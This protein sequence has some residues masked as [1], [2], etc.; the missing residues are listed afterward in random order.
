MDN[1]VVSENKKSF[2][3]NDK[4]LV[5]GMLSFY[6]LCIVGLIAGTFLWLGQMNRKIS[7]NATSTAQVVATQDANATATAIVRTTEQAKFG[8]VEKFDSNNQNWL[9]EKDEDE[10]AKSNI[11]V[12]DGMYIWDIEEVKKTFIYWADFPFNNNMKDFHVYVDTKLIANTPGDVCSGFLFRVAEEDWDKGGY[13]FS[14]CN[15]STATISYHTQ[16]DGWENITRLFDLGYANEW[17]RLEIIGKGT[18]FQFLINGTQAYEMDDDRQE[19]GGLA[20]VIEVNEKV[21]V[22]VLFDNFG[23]QR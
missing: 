14:L 17:N 15:D 5:C 6:G 10:Y 1:Q 20:L 12:K 19:L 2:W 18:N 21:P 13:Y 3:Q 9:T 11:Q 22:K 8:F 23:L 16:K 7:A 4:L